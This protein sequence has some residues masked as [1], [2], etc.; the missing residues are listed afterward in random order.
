[1]KVFWAF[2]VFVFW[3]SGASAECG[4]SYPSCALCQRFAQQGDRVRPAGCSGC[5]S[6]CVPSLTT[7]EVEKEINSKSG[8]KVSEGVL[9]VDSAPRTKDE[10]Y[11]IE[12]P[13]NQLSAIAQVN[14][15]AAVAL[16]LFTKEFHIE[17]ANT[18]TG[19]LAFGRIPTF[20][21][22]AQIMQGADDSTVENSQTP[23][24]QGKGFVRVKWKS[25]RSDPGSLRMTLESQKMDDQGQAVVGEAVYPA[26][27]VTM[28]SG[29]PGKI[30]AWALQ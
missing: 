16:L 28:Q 3:S 11:L 23:I 4:Y 27:V 6:I 7:P 14:P 22:V 25:V 2:L 15:M 12:I 17:S 20:T 29:R 21:T 13:K 5:T 19:E 30:S 24:P 18:L 9:Y 8:M 10:P 26:I 1:M